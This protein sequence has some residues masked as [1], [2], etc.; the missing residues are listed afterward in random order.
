MDLCES[1]LK[2]FCDNWKDSI[3]AVVDEGIS[4]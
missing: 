4:A 3:F 1:D 2:K